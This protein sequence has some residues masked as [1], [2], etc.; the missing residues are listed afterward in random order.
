MDVL[1]PNP[2]HVEA[3]FSIAVSDM[4]G[5]IDGMMEEEEAF[6]PITASPEP[7]CGRKLLSHACPA[8]AYKKRDGTSRIHPSR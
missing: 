3:L 2:A 8:N 5:S 4:T 6:A 1:R 7:Y